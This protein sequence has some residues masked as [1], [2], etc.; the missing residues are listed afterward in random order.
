LTDSSVRAYELALRLLRREGAS[1]SSG[2][3]VVI[4]AADRVLRRLQSELGRWFGAEGFHALLLRALDRARVGNELLAGVRIPLDGGDAEAHLLDGLFDGLRQEEPT[5]V[6]DATAAV[7]AAT[8]ALLGR[9]VGDDMAA[10][11]LQQSW[12]DVLPGE[13]HFT[14]EGSTE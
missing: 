4:A 5:A 1:D 7:V 14:D 6:L 9:L 10:R 8:I 2:C 3:T 12:P 13:P 11:L